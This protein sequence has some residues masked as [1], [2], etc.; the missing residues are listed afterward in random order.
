MR[1]A[2][3]TSPLL[4]GVIA[5]SAGVKKATGHAD[6]HI[7]LAQALVLG[8]GVAVFLLG[9]AL[10]RQ[11]L[12]LGTLRYRVMAAFAALLTVPLGVKISAILQLVGLVVVMAALVTVE[13]LHIKNQRLAT[14]GL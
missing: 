6:E 5:F 12:R 11:I 9:D 1:S 14:A 8:G 3:L 2:G 10:F 13:W 4:F 7:Y